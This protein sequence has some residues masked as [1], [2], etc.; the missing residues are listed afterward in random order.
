MQFSQRHR[1]IKFGFFIIRT[2]S[3][4]QTRNF[5]WLT[6]SH[7]PRSHREDE[8]E[9]KVAEVEKS[10]GRLGAWVEYLTCELQLR[11]LRQEC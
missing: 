5:W 8:M 1:P 4:D 7:W 2:Q 3:Y 11:H 10:K 9:A 6:G